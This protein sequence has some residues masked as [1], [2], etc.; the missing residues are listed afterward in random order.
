MAMQD[1]STIIK[2]DGAFYWGLFRHDKKENV[3]IE[4][5]LVDSW[6][7]HLRHHERMKVADRSIQEHAF[8]FHIDGKPPNVS[9]FIA[10]PFQTIIIERVMMTNNI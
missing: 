5:F 9:H 4:S 7:E 1:L 3:Y 6:V 8:A 10:G 2:R